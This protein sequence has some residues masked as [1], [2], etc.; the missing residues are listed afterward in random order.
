MLFPR[1]IVTLLFLTTESNSFSVASSNNNKE[2]A[3]TTTTSDIDQCSAPENN[4]NDN[5]MT[6]AATGK[7]RS[8][9]RILPRPPSHWVGDGFRVYPVFANSAFTED[10]S[11]MLMFDYAAPNDFPARGA[12]DGRPLGV[13]QHPHRG[14]ETVTIAFQGEVEHHD[15]KGGRGVIKPGDI[16]W[17]TAGKGIVH[18][19]YHSKE[20]TKTGG[21]FEMCQLWVNL[22]K[23]HKMTKPR[24]QPILNEQVP[25]VNLPLGS[26]SSH[27]KDTPVV[28]TARVIAG[29]LGETHG[30]AKTFS[31]VQ[32]WDISLPNE[33]SEV[34]IPFP[35]DH[36]CILFVRRGSV[37]VLS[38]NGGKDTVQVLKPQEVA[39]MRVDGSDTVKVRVKE[40]NSALLVMGGEPLNEPIAAQGPFVMNT[41]EEIYQAIS[42]YRMGKF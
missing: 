8:V 35:A 32:L 6:A 27:E 28:G 19:E 22:P 5:D 37:E 41:Q 13:G 7:F 42:D 30:V 29:D 31:P 15:N 40:S 4:N 12:A 38:H 34:E 16:Q 26:A 20:F 14:F 9:R 18:Q 10:V 33:D 1:L 17:M 36:N 2:F 11:P 25:V 21:T 24:Y 3:T 23:K 39:L